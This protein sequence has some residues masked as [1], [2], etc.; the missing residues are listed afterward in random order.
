MKRMLVVIAIALLIVVSNTAGAVSINKDVNDSIK[1]EQ[2]YKLR[3]VSIDA[4]GPVKSAVLDLIPGEKKTVL[5]GENFILYRGENLV[6]KGRL[7]TVFLGTLGELVQIKDL[8]QYD[9]DGTIILT[10]ERVLLFKPYHPPVKIT[11]ASETVKLKQ[12]YDLVLR[13]ADDTSTPQ[14]IWLQLSRNGN[15]VDDRVVALGESFSMYDG[16][17]LIVTSTFDQIFSGSESL[18]VRLTG[19]SQYNRSTGALML[20]L[21]RVMMVLPY[22]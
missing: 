22:S 19:L 10:L 8:V 11:P 9:E 5:S 12:G 20:Y 7:D 6:L 14:Q 18:M 4:S 17:A 15:S 21:D 3:L 2:N 16:S 1:L 13:A